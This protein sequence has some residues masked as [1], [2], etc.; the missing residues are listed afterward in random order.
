[1]KQNILYIVCKLISFVWHYIAPINR[2]K[3]VFISF[4][5]RTYNDNPKVISEG[6]FDNYG[7]DIK[8]IW[9]VDENKWKYL[10]PYV[11]AIK[12]SL[13]NHLIYLP[14][15]SVWVSNFS[16]PPSIY[17]S[18]GQYY[19]QTW[20]GDR[21][22]KKI[23]F[24]VPG[25]ENLKNNYLNSSK[26]IDLFIAGSK[27]GERMIR[28]AFHY[29]GEV[30]NIGCPRNDQLLRN[31]EQK[32]NAIKKLLG[33]KKG[34]RILMY[35]PT[36][37]DINKDKGTRQSI[38]LDMNIVLNTLSL[39]THSK[40]KIFVRLHSHMIKY[41]CNIK[42][43]EDIVSVS[44]Y[45]DMSDLLLITDVLVTDYSSSVGDFSLMGK[46]SLLFQGDRTLY[47]SNDRPLYFDMQKTPFIYA[48]T[49]DE[50]YALLNRFSELNGKENSRKINEFYEVTETGHSIE[51]ICEIIHNKFV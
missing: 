29:E 27:F 26:H 51:K 40:W 24:D 34:E 8:Q 48:E 33:V 7:S 4:G 3:V 50:F 5:G 21:A 20:H 12:P 22:F 13:I 45:P 49:T 39:A 1:M 18:P 47:E 38:P 19:I 15:S 25:R 46:L 16:L 44:D 41:G 14:I 42:F 11:K 37:R 30:L 31:D 32:V 23:G 35:A 9:L 43:T 2:N 36:F 10:P 6:L 17:K 28:S